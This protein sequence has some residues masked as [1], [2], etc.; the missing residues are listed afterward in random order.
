[1]FKRSSGMVLHISSLPSPYG[2]GSMGKA[3]YQFVDFLAKGGQTYWQVLPLGQTGFGDSPY[4]C[5]SAAAGNPYFIDL[6]TLVE[7][8]LLTE[9]QV[10]KAD[11]EKNPD[12]VDYEA[13]AQT[14]FE[15]LYQAFK[16]ASVEQLGKAAA[17]A[18]DNRSWVYDYA[19]FMSLKKHFDQKA[20]W[21]W[22]DEDIKRRDPEAMRRYAFELKDSIDFY[23]FMQ[24]LFFDQWNKLRAYANK[25]GISIIGDIPIYV[26]P[27]SCDVWA[28]PSLFKVD[29]ELKPNGV[30]G[31]PPDYY[32]ATGQL[33]GNP[34]YDWD[35]HRA[36][37]YQWWI[38]RVKRNLA[39]F[40]VTRIDH[41]RGFQDYWEIP[42]GEDT[43]ING[44]WVPGPRMELFDAI[45]NALGDVPIIA[46]DLGDIDDA[47]RG[48]LKESGYPGMRVLIFG[49][50]ENQDNIHLPH[51]H[52]VNCVAYTSTH[53]S[54]T[55][56]EQI[57]DKSRPEDASFAYEYLRSSHQEPLGWSAIRTV[58]A[59]PAAIAMTTM[60][61][62][63]S[64][65]SDA[66]MNTP[67]TL[68]GNWSWRVRAE[69][70]NDSIAQFLYK[71]TKA[72][73]RLNPNAR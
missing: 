52:P 3:A 22:D 30:A 17:F 61:D 27:D 6:D 21:D 59:S 28:N 42:A 60:Q 1:M 70:I 24:Y 55:V 54:E 5:F 48:F 46:E 2:I 35:V 9:E 39:L 10:K 64:L 56:C 63:L 7:M 23:I 15:V 25:K 73:K 47:V 13:L 14:R 43:A 68:G 8:G 69:A 19:M 38:W 11:V 49:L 41:F 20:L 29:E 44:K 72:T 58:F 34:V 66:R 53:D 32:S 65:G 57:M 71:V 62:V 4:Q 33:W 26:S 51:N 67:S 36:D 37:G 40:D 16:A 12:R 18:M 31:V 45:K 50:Y